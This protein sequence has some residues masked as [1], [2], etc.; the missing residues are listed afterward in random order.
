MNKFCHLIQLVFE[1]IHPP[2][3]IGK[4]FDL[5]YLNISYNQL[6]KIPESIRKCFDIQIIHFA[7]FLLKYNHLFTQIEI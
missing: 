5:K 7:L 4:C 3:E 6:T 1:I 2:D